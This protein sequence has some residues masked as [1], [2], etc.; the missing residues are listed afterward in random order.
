MP[1]PSRARFRIRLFLKQLTM[2]RNGRLTARE[3]GRALHY[4]G[5]VGEACRLRSGW[6]V[7][8]ARAHAHLNFNEGTARGQGSRGDAERASKRRRR[9]PQ[10]RR[11]KSCFRRTHTLLDERRCRLV[12]EHGR[13]AKNMARRV[14]H[15]R[16]RL[17]DARTFRVV[18]PCLGA[19]LAITLFM[20]AAT[21]ASV[22]A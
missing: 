19:L 13:G 12:E 7:V 15:Q 16:R 1:R 9:S 22:F 5:A 3:I 18:T 14:R 10:C 8:I 4:A 21:L 6:N 2:S 11:S 17:S 20:S